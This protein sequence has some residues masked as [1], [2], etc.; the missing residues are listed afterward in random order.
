MKRYFKHLAQLVRCR[1]IPS[2]RH[3]FARRADITE[4]ISSE[5]RSV[6]GVKRRWKDGVFIS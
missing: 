5:D 3:R 4:R 1:K 6:L 2:N